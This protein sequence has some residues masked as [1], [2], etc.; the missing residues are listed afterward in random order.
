MAIV[1]NKLVKCPLNMFVKPFNLKHTIHLPFVMYCDFESILKI[2][3][4]K[5]YPDKREHKLS[6]YC[7][8]L[9]C[10]ERPVF[11]KYKLYR[12][13]GKVSVID[14]FLNEAKNVLEH[15][16]QCEKRFYTLP[17][18]TDEQL[19]KH[20][21]TIHCQYCNVKFD[22]DNKKV[23]HHN[24]IS[25]EYI[26]TV[27]QSCNSKV[28]TNTT[29]CIIFHYLKGYDVHYIIEKLNDHFKDSNINLLGHNAS[30]IFHVGIQNYIK[31]I[32]SHEFIPMSLKDLSKNL[33]DEDINYTRHMVNKYGN[34]FIKKKNFSISLY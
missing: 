26:A 22:K 3:P 9:V 2:S 8:N 33:K 19:Q 15:I 25:S 14:H 29:L 7:Y 31:I 30:S 27:C 24:H 16:K 32:D 10:R 17:M 23:Q 1:D 28:K 18:L 5:K 12:G 4:D 6:S 13:D 34:D 11:N 20:K 21:K